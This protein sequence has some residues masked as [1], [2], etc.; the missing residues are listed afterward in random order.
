MMRV[1]LVSVLVLLLGGA[2]VPVPSSA[3]RVMDDRDLVT[4]RGGM[5]YRCV[6]TNGPCVVELTCPA[7]P[8]GQCFHY[9][10][11]IAYTT[12]DT[13]EYCRDG[14]PEQ[15]CQ[16]VEYPCTTTD[17]KCRQTSSGCKCGAPAAQTLSI[18][19]LLVAEGDPC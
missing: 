7:N 16:Q 2:R 12:G 18:G 9:Y 5:P 11:C 4:V 17:T 13:N 15:Q 1:C 8:A 19:V 14:S 3:G 10:W 6:F